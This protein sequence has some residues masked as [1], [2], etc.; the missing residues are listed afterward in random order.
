MS[1][2]LASSKPRLEAPSGKEKR[3]DWPLCY[4]AEK[5]VLD[6]LHAFLDRNS[7]A[8]QLSERMRAETGTLLLDW[9]DC[10]VLSPNNRELLRDVGYREDRLAETPSNQTAFWHPEAMLPRVL[11]DSTVVNAGFPAAVAIRTESISDFMAAHG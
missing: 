1:Q 4:P 9:V 2:V 10:L 5:F 3:F 8:R 11:L 6:H 7:F